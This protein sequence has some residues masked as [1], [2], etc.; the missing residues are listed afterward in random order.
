MHRLS[1]LLE[2]AF[3]TVFYVGLFYVILYYKYW[4]GYGKKEPKKPSEPGER[5]RERK[6]EPEKPSEPGELGC[7]RKKNPEK[8]PGYYHGERSINHAVAYVQK[9]K[10][11][12]LFYE[13]M[14]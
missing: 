5:G 14:D 11:W 13:G 3:Q 4:F 12:I 9:M 6:K 7:E 8:L 10:K 1:K 2:K